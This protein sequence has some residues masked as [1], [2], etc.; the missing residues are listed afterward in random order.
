MKVVGVTA[1]S[2]PAPRLFTDGLEVRA[3]TLFESLAR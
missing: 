2:R 3:G 1:T